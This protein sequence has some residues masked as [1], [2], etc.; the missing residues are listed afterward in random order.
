MRLRSNDI[1]RMF[2]R[3]PPKVQLIVGA[4]AVVVIGGLWVTGNLPAGLDGGNSFTSAETDRSRA[5]R[6][7]QR[8]TSSNAQPRRTTSTE[9][10][11][12]NFDYYV[13]ALSW[14][15]TYCEDAGRKRG[16]Q[17]CA[18]PRPYAFVLHGLWPQFRKG[19]PENCG[20]RR[21]WVPKP[22]I[23][24]MLDI[25]PSRGLIIH[26][27]K[28]HGTCSGLDAEGYFALSRDLYN[29]VKI[30]PVFIRPER[31][32]SMSP[33]DVER[34]FL[35]ANTKMNASMLA[36]TCGRK[37]RLKEVRVCFSK[38]GKL[39]SCGVNETQK[40]LCSRNNLRIPPVRSGRRS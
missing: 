31:A 9:N 8:E 3:L 15:P 14:S 6:P 30:P 36:V 13:L 12:A 28:K 34:A 27:Y 2:R 40:R 17:Q 23:S 1:V 4:L 25:M 5:A 7:S 26:E 33:Q 11:N 21:V 39:A 35:K 18:G 29:K 10:A 38:D 19:W 20:K 37:S 16:G 32:L 24:R 22:I